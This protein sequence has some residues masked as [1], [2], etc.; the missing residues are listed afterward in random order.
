MHNIYQ[1]PQEQIIAFALVFLRV[2]G[3]I[4]TGPIFGVPMV[5]V[6]LKVLLA[7]LLSILLFPVVNFQNNGL[8]AMNSDLI[9]VAAKEITVGVIIGYTV[10][11][12]FFAV[13]MGSELIAMSMGLS[14]AQIF[15]PT[16]GNYGNVL[17]QFTSALA[18]LIFFAV[19]GHHM[20]L[21]GL[22]ESFELIK[23]TELGFQYQGF[24]SMGPL[25]SDAFT[26]AFKIAAPIICA[27]FLAN[28]S[29]G[30]LGRAVPQ[31]NVLVTSMTI[32]IGLGFFVMILTL[33]LFF[34]EL[35]QLLEMMTSGLFQ[36]MK[37]I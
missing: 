31:I 29:M 6:Q 4:V 30:I 25:V 10:R 14:S 23:V 7:L 16:M 12:F 35:T 28:V 22:F 17:E 33:P 36:M 27:V 26:M 37:V 34:Q 9:L 11:M 8:L 19:N 21:T 15:N 20:F 2:L 32:T 1:F 24:A 3:F 13:S 18:T 5:P